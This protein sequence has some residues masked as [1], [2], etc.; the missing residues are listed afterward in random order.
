ML[1]NYSAVVLNA[2]NTEVDSPLS[3]L[4]WASTIH[5]HHLA[6]FFEDLHHNWSEVVNSCRVNLGGF[7]TRKVVGLT[8]LS[9]TLTDKIQKLQLR[10]TVKV[11]KDQTKT[12]TPQVRYC[13]ALAR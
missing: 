3:F 9:K 1:Q 5:R 7:K 10:E 6:D 12:I 4:S 13:E 2:A 11:A 8:D